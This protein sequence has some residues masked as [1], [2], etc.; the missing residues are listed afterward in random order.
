M[1]PI[2]PGIKLDENCLLH[3]EVTALTMRNTT[4]NRHPEPQSFASLLD[5]QLPKAQEAF[6]FPLATTMHKA[7]KFELVNV[8]E[9][10]SRWHYKFSSLGEAFS[11]A[12]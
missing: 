7:G 10:E 4:N 1:C 5:A 9:A 2:T 12:P 8:I 6:Q 3:S 11:K